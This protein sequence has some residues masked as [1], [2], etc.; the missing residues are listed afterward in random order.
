MPFQMMGVRLDAHRHD[1]GVHLAAAK[2]V[3]EDGPEVG[4]G[5]D[6]LGGTHGVQEAADLPG[7]VQR[8]VE[9]P[10]HL[11]V[12]LHGDEDGGG[13]DG[14]EYLPF[15]EARPGSL[16]D[17]AGLLEFAIGG[18][19]EPQDVPLPAAGGFDPGQEPFPALEKEFQFLRVH[20]QGGLDTVLLTK[21]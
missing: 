13:E 15:R 5:E 6:G 4:D 17:G 18:Y 7:R 9:D 11:P 12:M 21:L 3:Q 8:Q 19:V 14:Q 1:I 16:D 10:V 20:R 2:G